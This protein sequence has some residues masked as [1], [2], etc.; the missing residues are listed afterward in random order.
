MFFSLSTSSKSSFWEQSVLGIFPSF[1]GVLILYL[2]MP[3]GLQAMFALVSANILT[4]LYAAV[5]KPIH[6]NP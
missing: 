3:A 6:Q 4:S 5:F 2:R 1:S